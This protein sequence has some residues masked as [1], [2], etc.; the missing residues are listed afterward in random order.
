MLERRGRRYRVAACL[1]VAVVAA[2]TAHAAGPVVAWGSNV[3]GESTPPASV[4]GPRRTASA[5]S[6]AISH[7]CAIVA[8]TGA[9]I[10]WGDNSTGQSTPPDS[11]NG[12]AGTA[13]AIA[14]G[15]LHSLAIRIPEPTSALRAIASIGTLFG[16]ARRRR[17]RGSS[18]RSRRPSEAECVALADVASQAA[19]F[20]QTLA[21]GEACRGEEGEVRGAGDRTH[22]RP[23]LIYDG[24]SSPRRYPT[25]PLRFAGVRGR[26]GRAPR[27][28]ADA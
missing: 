18:N 17:R 24:G 6:A 8:E 9:V 22:T 3:F 1:S 15:G 20:G 27:R 12:V 28:Y 19:G 26:A 5:V 14:V 4:G 13:S 10:C 23:W 21:G 2:S 16:L 7:S 11:V 25:S